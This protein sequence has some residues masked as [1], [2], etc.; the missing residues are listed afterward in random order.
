MVPA[1]LG[2]VEFLHHV[3]GIGQKLPDHLRGRSDVGRDGAL[4]S[5][6]RLRCRR[7]DRSRVSHSPIVTVDTRL[8]A[9]WAAR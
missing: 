5:E 1:M 7:H 6:E 4:A 8:T 9:Q 3:V 2:S